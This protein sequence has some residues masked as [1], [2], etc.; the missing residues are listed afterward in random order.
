MF[1]AH[2]AFQIPGN[3]LAKRFGV[4]SNIG[5]SFMFK[6]KKN[7]IS[8][9]EF[10][11]IFGNVIKEDTT[12]NIIST[13]EGLVIGGDGIYADVNQFQRGFYAAAKLGKIIPFYGPNPNSGILIYGSCGLLQH[14]IR[15][16]VTDNT[17]PQLLKKELKKGYD[18]LANGLGISEFIGYIYMGNNRLISFYAGLEF[19]QAWTKSRRTW[20]FD[21]MGKDTQ[22]RYDTQYSIKIGWIIPLYKKSSKTGYYYF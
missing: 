10:N 3:D 9:V 16:E 11:F 8:G 4:N 13:K 18:H 12:L 1:T 6:N 19:N 22:N 17:A 14:K 7:W 5:G 2:Y 20:D 21:R 15:T